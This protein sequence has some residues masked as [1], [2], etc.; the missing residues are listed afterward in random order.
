MPRD[1]DNDDSDEEPDGEDETYADECSGIAVKVKFPPDSDKLP[2]ELMIN[3]SKP[4]NHAMGDVGG[5]PGDDQDRVPAKAGSDNPF[6][7]EDSNPDK[8]SD[9]VS[10]PED[11]NQS[12]SDRFKFDLKMPGASPRRVRC[13]HFIL[14]F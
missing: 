3:G 11:S 10:V 7:I 12:L 13:N 14:I 8:A 5:D 6:Q 1:D 2:P 9:K 4:I